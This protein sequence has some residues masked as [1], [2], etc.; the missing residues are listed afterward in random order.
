MIRRDGTRYLHRAIN[1]KNAPNDEL[2]MNVF[3]R[4]IVG[5][6]RQ[7]AIYFSERR[8]PETY[9]VG[10]KQDANDMLKAYAMAINEND[11]EFFIWT[12]NA[13]LNHMEKVH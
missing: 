5:R 4:C 8:A 13:F 3:T 11:N 7:G 10:C 12:L 9:C 1:L 6:C 2:D